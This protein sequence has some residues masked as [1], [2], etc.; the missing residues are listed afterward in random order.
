M[1]KRIEINKKA[2]SYSRRSRERILSEKLFVFCE[3]LNVSHILFVGL[4]YLAKSV[5]E[6]C[7]MFTCWFPASHPVIVG[8]FRDPK[9]GSIFP[10]SHTVSNRNEPYLLATRRY[11]LSPP[12]SPNSL[13]ATRFFT[14][15]DTP[16]YRQSRQSESNF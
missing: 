7:C 16:E 10:H 1:W 15:H 2:P 6:L 5:P 12:S 9:T 14:N 8:R 13:I 4:S 3:F 11:N